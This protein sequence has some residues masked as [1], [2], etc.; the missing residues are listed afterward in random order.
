MA[1][2]L[3]KPQQL[4]HKRP[5]RWTVLLTG[6]NQG[7]SVLIIKPFYPLFLVPTLRTWDFL[8]RLGGILQTLVGVKPSEFSATLCTPIPPN[9]QSQGMEGRTNV[10]V[11]FLLCIIP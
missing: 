1:R 10:H 3:K 8:S 9:S 7:C 11:I 2:S 4:Q 5:A 6:I